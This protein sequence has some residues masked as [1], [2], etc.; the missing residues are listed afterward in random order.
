MVYFQGLLF[1]HQL[2]SFAWKLECYCWIYLKIRCS[3]LKHLYNFVGLAPLAAFGYVMAT[4]LS[5]YPAILI[6]P[7]RATTAISIFFLSLIILMISAIKLH[8]WLLNSL[9]GHSFVGVWSR[10]SSNKSISCEKLK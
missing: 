10:C 3:I 4:H 7:V 9:A 6:V 5:L 2:A 8:C 1:A